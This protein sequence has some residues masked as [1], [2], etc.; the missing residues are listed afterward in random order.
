MK[1]FQALKNITK[2]GEFLGFGDV[3]DRGWNIFFGSN[4]MTESA[5]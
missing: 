1:T 4:K 2:V 3:S 5:Y